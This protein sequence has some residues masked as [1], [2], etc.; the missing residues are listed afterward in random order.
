M[1][2]I[3]GLDAS[4]TVDEMI[5]KINEQIDSVNAQLI[6]DEAHGGTVI[7]LSSNY[8]GLD[9][10]LSGVVAETVFG[11][12]SAATVSSDLRSASTP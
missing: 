7:Q 1:L 10:S 6:Y 4:A 5:E 9:V 12:D 3:T 8:V 2:T 11:I